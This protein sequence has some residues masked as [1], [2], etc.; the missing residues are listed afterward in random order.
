MKVSKQAQSSMQ[1][2]KLHWQNVCVR[3]RRHRIYMFRPSFELERT[4]I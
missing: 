2:D 1:F 4:D 3:C